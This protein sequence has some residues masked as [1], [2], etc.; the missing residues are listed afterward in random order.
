MFTFQDLFI[1]GH[2]EVIYRLVWVL[3]YCPI[4]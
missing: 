2:K 1:Y 3:Y 4:K